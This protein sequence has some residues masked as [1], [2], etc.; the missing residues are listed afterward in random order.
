MIINGVMY[1][2]GGVVHKRTSKNSAE[3]CIYDFQSIAAKFSTKTEWGAGDMIKGYGWVNWCTLGVQRLYTNIKMSCINDFESIV[4]KFST[5]TEYGLGVFV[6]KRRNVAQMYINY[7]PSITIKCFTNTQYGGTASMSSPPPLLSRTDKLIALDM[8]VHKRC[9]YMYECAQIT[10]K[11][12][13]W[14]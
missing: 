14:K 5:N 9:R 3:T 11:R 13:P 10:R 12:L 8:S 4:V 7:A 6:H 2:R 1:F